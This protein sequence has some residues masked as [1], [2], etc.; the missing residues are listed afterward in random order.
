M[1]ENKGSVPHILHNGYYKAKS[2]L[3]AQCDVGNIPMQTGFSPDVWQNL[4]NFSIEKQPANFI[5]QK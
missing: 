2:D 1:K 3:L 5:F 4:T